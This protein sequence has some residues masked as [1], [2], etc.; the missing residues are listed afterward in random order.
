M[1]CLREHDVAA[2]RPG[3]N[4]RQIRLVARHDR[5]IGERDADGGHLRS[6][7]WRLDIGGAKVEEV[8]PLAR[9]LRAGDLSGRRVDNGEQSIAEE[10]VLGHL[11]GVQLLPHHRLHRV[12]PEPDNG[13]T[14]FWRR[15]RL[16]RIRLHDN[17]F[18]SGLD[19]GQSVSLR[20]PTVKPG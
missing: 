9:M 10:A 1:P 8:A 13:T 19:R 2:K 6:R 14:P 7:L 17:P 12:A 5:P 4:L 18:D 15:R 16:R 11:G 20:R 3:K